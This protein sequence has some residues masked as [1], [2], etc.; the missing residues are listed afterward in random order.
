MA[1]VPRPVWALP[2]ACGAGSEARGRQR[3]CPQEPERGGAATLLD[4]D[5]TQLEEWP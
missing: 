5:Q 1:K 4:L 2:S 3:I